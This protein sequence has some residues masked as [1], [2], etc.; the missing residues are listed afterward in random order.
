[1]NARDAMPAGGVLRLATFNQV[2]RSEVVSLHDR[3]PGGNY[4][5]LEVTDTGMGIEPDVMARIFEPFFTTKD[6]GHGTGLGLPTVYGIMKQSGGY[7]AVHS[8]A[9]RGCRFRL[10]FPALPDEIVAPPRQSVETH[11]E[12]GTATILLIEDETAVR[13]LAKR[14][15]EKVGYSVLDAP[16]GHSAVALAKRYRGQVDL[17]VSDVVLPDINGREAADQIRTLHPH[18]RVLF[19]SGYTEDE[20][21]HRG[22]LSNGLNFLQ[23]PFA[24]KDLIAKV[25][26]V[27]D[28]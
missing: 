11:V 23:K 20:V 22:V 7:V 18:T 10:L 25:R 28:T 9:R 27:L 24:P 4:V 15:L 13:A 2:Y 5:C 14:T 19:M 26:A 6:V 12:A 3:I 8:E 21:I 16:A 17:V 1:V